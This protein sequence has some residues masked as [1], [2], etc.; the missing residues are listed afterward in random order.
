MTTT[1]PTFVFGL[2]GSPNINDAYPVYEDTIKTDRAMG[3]ITLDYAVSDDVLFYA[4]IAN[5]F[6]SG[7]FNGANSNTT[8]QLTPIEPETLTSYEAGVKATL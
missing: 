5:G 6:K 7:G 2:L 1:S 8:L 4:T 3:K